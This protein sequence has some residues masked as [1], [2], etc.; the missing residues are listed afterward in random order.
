MLVLRRA[1]GDGWSKMSQRVRRFGLDGG[2]PAFSRTGE[3]PVD[4]TLARSLLAAFQSIFAPTKPFDVE[5]LP[6]LDLVL[7]PELGRDHDSAIT[8]DGGL[9]DPKIPS[10]AIAL[11]RLRDPMP[12][13]G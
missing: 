2:E 10:C 6:W 9:H 5:F 13:I 1:R 11:K 8:G 3:Q 7:T 4:Q 12:F